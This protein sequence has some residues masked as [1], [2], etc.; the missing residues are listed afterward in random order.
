M[1]DWIAKRVTGFTASEIEI[2][3]ARTRF[4]EAR[5][6][7]L[8]LENVRLESQH[9]ANL[10][11]IADLQAHIENLKRKKDSVFSQENIE[12]FVGGIR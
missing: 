4:L 7:G 2:L 5:V 6:D 9:L 10:K 12:N 11:L 3:L 1:K 8:Q